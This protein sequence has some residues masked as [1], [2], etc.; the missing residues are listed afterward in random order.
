MKKILSKGSIRNKTLRNR[1]DLSPL[2]KTA[3]HRYHH[4]SVSDFDKWM[5]MLSEKERAIVKNRFGWWTDEDWE[6]K[7]PHLRYA[8]QVKIYEVIDRAITRV[9]ELRPHVAGLGLV[10]ALLMDL[11]ENYEIKKKE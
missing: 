1:K 7:Y 9:N 2:L 3:I 6:I 8:G 10:K 5:E 11:K 4:N